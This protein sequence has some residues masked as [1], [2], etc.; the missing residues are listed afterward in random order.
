MKKIDLKVLSLGLILVV[1]LIATRWIEGPQ[2][3]TASMAVFLFSAAYFRSFVGRI[4][5][6]FAALFVSDLVLGLH[7]IHW[8]VYGSYFIIA[9]MAVLC[10]AQ[11]N[12][13]KVFAT[14]LI[15]SLFFFLVTNFGVWWQSGLYASS[16]EGLMQAYTMAL[17]FFRNSLLS[18]V[19]LSLAVFYVAQSLSR[20]QI[21]SPSL[22]FEANRPATGRSI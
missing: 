9:A 2:N 12:F 7:S 4:L 3:F 17:P 11:W 21:I 10:L 8:F 14:S 16:W 22:V 5:L 18:N 15:G 20:S 19:G 13:K 1:G 6:P